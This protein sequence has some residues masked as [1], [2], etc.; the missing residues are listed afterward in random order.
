MRMA[1]PELDAG[2]F[3]TDGEL[4]IRSWNGW[5]ARVTGIGAEEAVGRPLATL[6]PEIEARGL[7]SRF[8][9]VLAEGV[10]EV[11]SPRL[12]HYLIPCPPPFPSR[13]FPLMQQRVTILPLREGERVVGT[14]VL[15]EDVT[16]RLEAEREP[17]ATGMPEEVLV[18]GLRE[19]RW[20]S[21]QLALEQLA[22]EGGDETIRALLQLLQEGHED[23]NVLT[24]VLHVLIH[25]DADITAPLC[26]FLEAPDAALRTYAALALGE[27]RDREALPALLRALDDPD[28]NVRYHA[29][30]ALGKLQATEAV[31]RLLQFVESRDFFLAFPALDALARIG[32]PGIAPRLVP[33][34]RDELLRAAAVDVLG[35]LGDADVVAP[36]VAL[37][38]E[39]G[40]PVRTI[41][42]ALATL[43][44]R[45]EAQYGE[46]AV[47]AELARDALDARAVPPLLEEIR[48]AQGDDLRPLALVLGWLEGPEVERALVRLLAEPAVHKEV[49][50]ALVRYGPRVTALLVDLL[51]SEDPGIGR[52]A[53]VA[54]GRIGDPAAV[55]ALVE[56]LSGEEGLAIEAAGA[57]ARIGDRRACEPLL[58]LLGHPNAAVRRAAIG[59]LNS[60]GHPE[61][62]GRIREM[63]LDPDPR[64]RESATRIAG[65]FAYP[66]CRERLLE[67]CQDE[68][69]AVRSAAVEVLPYLEE[70]RSMALLAR[71]LREDTPRVRAAAARALGQVEG[72]DALTALLE[73]LG[74]TEPWVRYQAV[75]AIERHASPEAVEPLAQL[76]RSDSAIP[77][78][79]AAIEALGAIGGSR[80]VALLA[81]LVDAEEADLARSAIAALGRIAHPDAI[82]PLLEALR[83]PDVMRR[84]EAAAAL[85]RHAESG[86]VE[87]LQWTAAVDPDP[88]VVQAAVDALERMAT[89]EALAALLSLS[90]DPG[91]HEVCIRALAR[92]SQG[93]IEALARGLHHPNPAVRCAVVEVLA[94]LKHPAASDL[95]AGALEDGHPSVRLAAVTALARLGNRRAE[96]RVA[97]LAREDPDLVVRRAAR[98]ALGLRQEEG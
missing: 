4:V 15:L 91:R 17:K 10:V 7:L 54:L 85:G 79:A 49:V 6:F 87:L 21:R 88:R 84:V 63:L 20:P 55:P 58:A 73:A 81:P 56:A 24:S 12:H 52:A 76:V 53:A 32:D 37:L 60:L 31:D 47:I 38:G 94:R 29:I 92:P 71:A 82:L 61:M 11:L 26:R 78:R 42:L 40:M 93:R 66:E 27:R 33:L 14:M 65:Y 19:E 43:Y 16:A 67:R 62:P 86:V 39:P 96:Q 97:A 8:R 51:R 90:A 69:E 59:A 35:H 18:R 25:T 74:D 44:D 28:A 75:R 30:E 77:V 5:L 80:V 2:L 13:R 95:L 70:A 9:R 3:T 68:D 57:L 34:L 41:A 64:V 83:S 22:G 45:Y 23:L 98:Q 1:V 72:G 46:G 50:Q 89:P 48:E 36:L